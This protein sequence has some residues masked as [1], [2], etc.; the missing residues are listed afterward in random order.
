MKGIFISFNRR[1]DKL[2]LMV[3]N[4]LAN[5]QTISQNEKYALTEFIISETWQAWN[6][7]SKDMIIKSVQGGIARDG[8]CVPIRLGAKSDYWRICYEASCYAKSQNIKASG[9]LNF[10]FYNA[11]TWGDVDK[12]PSVINGLMPA[13]GPRLLSGFGAMTHIRDLQAIRNACAHKCNEVIA[14]LKPKLMVKYN[15]RMVKHPADY[16]WMYTLVGND[17]AYF[18]WVNEMKNTALYITESN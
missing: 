3:A 11:H 9:H 17:I 16:A 10:K 12:I 6:A 7:F 13:N 2:S 8:S 18:L 1:L 15:I 5:S 14:D 4:V